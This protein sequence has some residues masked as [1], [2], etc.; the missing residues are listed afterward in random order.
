MK[1]L[2]NLAILSSL[3]ISV[4]SYAGS[5]VAVTSCASESGRTKV[6][7]LNQD[8]VQFISIKFTI[9][10]ESKTYA[11]DTMDGVGEI[12]SD[13]ANVDKASDKVFTVSARSEKEGNVGSVE[14]WALPSTI[15][16]VNS[17]DGTIYQFKAN[18]RGTDPRASKQG[19]FS[20]LI[21]VKCKLVYSI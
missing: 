8:R 12:D 16:Q 20:P 14:L 9:D 1:H 3:V 21:E 4:F 2:K 10:G 5:A 18:I 17:D 19:E 11:V 6:E 7:I 13:G 15:T